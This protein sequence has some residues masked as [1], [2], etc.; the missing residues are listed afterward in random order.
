MQQMLGHDGPPTNFWR[1]NL[2]TGKPLAECPLRTILRMQE[3]DPH[4]SRE[5]DTHLRYYGAYDRGVLL[6]AG[7]ISD[8]PA[9]YVELMAL[10][11]QQKNE[12]E[13]KH[14]ELLKA[15]ADETPGTA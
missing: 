9:R 8:Q 12:T 1:E 2:L 3:T 5:V 14:L 7:G 15:N 10:I 4:L 13:A 6:V 11:D